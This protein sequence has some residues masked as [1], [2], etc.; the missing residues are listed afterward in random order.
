MPFPAYRRDPLGLGGMS[1]SRQE[2]RN[3]GRS[4][5]AHA[6]APLS[7]VEA[8]AIIYELTAVADD[9]K[10]AAG[11]CDAC[12]STSGE[13]KSCHSCGFV[14]YCNREC[15]TAGWP[16]HKLACKALAFDK[17]IS[18]TVSLSLSTPVPLLPLDKMWDGIRTGSGADVYVATAHLNILL[19]R[20]C[21]ALEESPDGGNRDGGDIRDEIAPRDGI[22][23]LVDMLR[24]GGMKAS[25]VALLLGRYIKDRPDIG[26][27]VVS[28]GALPYLVNMI[29]LPSKHEALSKYWSLRLAVV[30]ASDVL[31]TLAGLY[32]LWGAVL[33]AGAVPAIVSVMKLPEDLPRQHPVSFAELNTRGRAIRALC[34]CFM[35]APGSVGI[36]D[37]D[38]IDHE[39]GPAVTRACLAAGAVPPLLAALASK[40]VETAAA[41]A[42]ALG[43]I[44]SDSGDA[45]LARKALRDPAKIMAIVRLGCEE[46][47]R[48]AL[49]LMHHVTSAALPLCRPVVDAGLMPLAV[50]FL[51][52]VEKSTALAC[53]A[54]IAIGSLCQ[55]PHTAALALDAGVLRRLPALLKGKNAGLHIAALTTIS[56]ALSK[57]SGAQRAEALSLGLP[58]LV[59][60]CLST[61]LLA[62]ASVVALVAFFVVLREGQES[63]AD[64][65]AFFDQ[66]FEGFPASRLVAIIDQRDDL[67]D[68]LAGALH[69]MPDS[70]AHHGA[71]LR[72]G[73]PR[74]LVALLTVPGTAKGGCRLARRPDEICF[75]DKRAGLLRW[76]P[77]SGSPGSPPQR[78]Q[79]RRGGRRHCEGGGPVAARRYPGYGR[80]SRRCRGLLHHEDR[81][82]ERSAPQGRG[83]VRGRRCHD[84]PAG[85][86]GPLRSPLRQNGLL[87]SNHRGHGVQRIHPRGPLCGA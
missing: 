73:L 31:G 14:R 39:R 63:L 29:A 45:D 77:R 36:D 17:E 74:S 37:V 21:I 3:F 34:R 86:Q 75:E 16:A 8:S 76:S 38:R 67:A 24:A 19:K 13:R 20:T 85:C 68:R 79:R 84:G 2:R 44:I 60:R 32:G 72:A 10:L 51:D 18:T 28:A 70:P 7:E 81:G 53:H 35:E 47:A 82:G 87:L 48:Q 66:V 23:L 59:A 6:K 57:A 61:P 50:S 40:D 56:A 4:L 64:A 78:T 26:A 30:A 27:A 41:A 80:P 5:R 11:R 9:V 58:R 65:P 54:G 25:G 52:G 49:S 46:E 12:L 43:H 69:A 42:E 71:W 33:E 83:C 1:G 55:D 15:Q 22:P 62:E